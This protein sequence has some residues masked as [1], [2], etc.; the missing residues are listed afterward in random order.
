VKGE[1]RRARE[2]TVSAGEDLESQFTALYEQH[3]DFVWRS[4]RML[5]LSSDT[6]DDVVQDVFIVAHRRLGDFEAR[7]SVRTWLFAIARRVVSSHRRGQRRRFRLAARVSS[8][9]RETA[10][11][12]HD[13]LVQSESQRALV[14]ALD[15]LPEEQ[16][17][18]FA[19]TE[20]EEMSATEIAAALGVN[21]N[22]IYSRLRIARRALAKYM[23]AL[24]REAEP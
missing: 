14:H 10:A 15:T 18:V 5:G 9:D 20:L 12:P 6:A 3:F 23:R 2:A 16:R 19:L 1:H 4:V 7:A 17:I 21:L 8:V 24:E 22:T 13:T 11:T